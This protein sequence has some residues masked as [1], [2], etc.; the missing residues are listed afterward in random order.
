MPCCQEHELYL[1]AIQAGCCFQFTPTAKAVYRIWSDETLCR[2]DPVLVIK[3]RTE[4]IDR[5]LGWL[6]QNGQITPIHKNIAGRAFFEM[7]RTWARHDLNRAA[8]YLEGNQS[9]GL[10]QLN[11][12]A[13]PLLYRVCF[14]LFGFKN[15]ER[16][17]K[18]L[19]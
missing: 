7:A 14:R 10:L 19:R 6:E 13:A 5:M 16:I 15:A 9:R 17:A 1:R 3:T 2:K 11:G 4:L 8:D 18:Q 12:P